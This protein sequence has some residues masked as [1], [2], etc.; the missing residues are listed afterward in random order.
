MGD[1]P[2]G[3]YGYFHFTE[4][5]VRTEGSCSHRASLLALYIIHALPSLT[6]R[7]PLQGK[8]ILIRT[9]K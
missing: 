6:I 3:N 5:A 7:P 1:E 2:G 9:P 8:R 4:F